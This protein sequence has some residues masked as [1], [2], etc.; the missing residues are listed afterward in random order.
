M[1]MVS[2]GAL[3]QIAKIQRLENTIDVM[4]FSKEEWVTIANLRC[5][6]NFDDR[7]IRE[8]FKDNGV[9]STSVKIFTFRYFDNV[10]VKDRILYRNMTYEITGIQNI[11][12][13][14][15][16]LKIWGRCVE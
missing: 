8:V 2:I 14:N 12:E 10:T 6:V 15:R 9:D 11:G 7:Q 16:F 13:E 4:G 1:T 5:S 3:K